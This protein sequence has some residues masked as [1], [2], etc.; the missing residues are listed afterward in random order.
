MA[1][2]GRAWPQT[3]AGK[4]PDAVAAMIA[5][6]DAV[7]ILQKLTV[8]SQSATSGTRSPSVAAARLELEH[9]AH[10]RHRLGARVLL[11][12]SLRLLLS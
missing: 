7:N 11:D 3:P 5:D 4:N 8:R 9:A 10:E 2:V 12:E 6:M 1:A